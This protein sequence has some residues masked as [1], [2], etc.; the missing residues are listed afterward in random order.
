MYFQTR[1]THLHR[2]VLVFLIVQNYYAPIKIPALIRNFM[3]IEDISIKFLL[4]Q[5]VGIT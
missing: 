5:T 1:T 3:N 4:P 2:V